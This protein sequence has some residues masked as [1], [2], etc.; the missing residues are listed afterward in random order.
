VR[1]PRELVPDDWAPS[2]E[3]PDSVNYLIQ[4]TTSHA[5]N[6]AGDAISAGAVFYAPHVPVAGF[7][8][9]I[10]NIAPVPV[11]VATTTDKV[12]KLVASLFKKAGTEVPSDLS[13]D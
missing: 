11:K 4:E 13:L 8:A 1:K 9:P 7:L 6:Q 5:P 10:M 12:Q 3:Y 2:L